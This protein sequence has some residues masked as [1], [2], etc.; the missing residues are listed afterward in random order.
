M[1][2]PKAYDGPDRRLSFRRDEDVSLKQYVET[3]LNLLTAD[4]VNRVRVLRDEVVTAAAGADLR[5]QQRFEAQSLALGAAAM[6]AKEA[7][8]AAL[9][10]AKE[11]VSKTE[12]SADKRFEALGL[13]IEQRF[14]AMGEKID[15]LARAAETLQGRVNL[16]TGAASGVQMSR[17]N[18]RNQLMLLVAVVGALIALAVYFKK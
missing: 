14:K 8:Q 4:L 12:L 1:T 7:V 16:S 2:D 3:R 17:D 5:Y 6:A 15:D 13:L 9:Q 18:A 10:A 11:A